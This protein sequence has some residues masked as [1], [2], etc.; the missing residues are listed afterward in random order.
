MSAA[1]P[2]LTFTVRRAE[3]IKRLVD[4]LGKRNM[5]MGEIAQFLDLTLTAVRKYI[6]IMRRYAVLEIARHDDDNRPVFRL[7]RND[8]HVQAF[9]IALNAML[10]RAKAKKSGPLNYSPPTITA[11]ARIEAYVTEHP[12]TLAAAVCIA[13][14]IAKGRCNKLMGNLR[15]DGRIKQ[16]SSNGR[17]TLWAAGEDPQLTLMGK[18]GFVASRK[19]VTRWEP[20]LTGDPLALHPDFFKPSDGY[21]ERRI[22]EPVERV[23]V[24]GFAALAQVR[25][26]MTSGAA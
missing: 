24:T 20:V 19:C 6:P 13:L 26:E 14:D 18:A 16:T 25:F 9:R 12:N 17:G 7:P 5:S 11:M 10:D 3:N 21:C 8:A 2:V 23:R 4:E 1:L 15:Q 22:T